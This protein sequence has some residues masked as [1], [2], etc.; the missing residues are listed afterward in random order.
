MY[1]KEISDRPLE[2]ENVDGDFVLRHH[3]AYDEKLVLEISRDRNN[4]EE[5]EQVIGI[6]ITRDRAI[7]L[8]DALENFIEC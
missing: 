8:R 3:L 2:G 4:G 5:F 6:N 1:I 7:R